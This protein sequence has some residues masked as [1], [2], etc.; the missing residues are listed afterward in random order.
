MRRASR[1]LQEGYTYHLTHRCHDQRFLLRFARE[2]KAYREWLRVGA[3]RYGVSVYGY[4]ITSS[5]THVI[6][7]VDNLNDVAQMM[8]LAAGAV[9]RALNYRK[10]HEGS[11]WEHPYQCTMVENGQHLLNCL[12]YVDMN[13]VRA[14]VV[15]HP[16]EWRWCGFSELTGLRQRYRMLDRAEV[17]RMHDGCMAEEFAESYRATIDES[18]ALR[19]AANSTAGRAEGLERDQMWT[20]SIAVGSEPFVRKIEQET[21]SRMELDITPTSSGAGTIRETPEPYG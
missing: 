8:Q 21:R 15:A 3:K 13:M 6:V 5:H 14:G 9:G 18:L 11:V 19:S 4:C 16:Q 2:R 17:L 20:E 1:Y 10:S 7:H 12:R